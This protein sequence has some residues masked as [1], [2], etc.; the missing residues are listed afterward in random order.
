MNDKENIIRNYLTID[1]ED[2]FQVAAFDDV[3]NPTDPTEPEPKPEKQ[4]PGETEP[5]ETEEE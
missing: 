5:D 4:K 1:V 3:I 2:Y